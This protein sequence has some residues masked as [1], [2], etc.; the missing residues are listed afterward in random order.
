M[1]VQIDHVPGILQEA[2]VRGVKLDITLL[3][4]SCPKINEYF[5]IDM[6]IKR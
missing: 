6:N 2:L 5:G 4:P 1:G 3:V